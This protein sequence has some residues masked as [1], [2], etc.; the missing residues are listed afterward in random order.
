MALRWLRQRK[1]N[2]WKSSIIKWKTLACPRSTN[3]VCTFVC[4]IKVHR[5]K[6]HKEPANINKFCF[7][8]KQL[9]PK[10]QA[11]ILV[12]KSPPPCKIK[13]TKMLIQS[14]KVW[15]K[16]LKLFKDM[17]SNYCVPYSHISTS[18]HTIIEKFR[19][20]KIFIVLISNCYFPT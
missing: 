3:R 7:V 4:Y 20:T 18:L 16:M 15:S 10:I 13:Q 12:K 9:F 14:S 19:P 1:P 6:V 11:H 8:D 5:N 17:H 2:I